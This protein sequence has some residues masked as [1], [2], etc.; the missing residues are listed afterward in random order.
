LPAEIPQALAMLSDDRR[1]SALNERFVFQFALDCLQLG[2][3]LRYFFIEPF[4]FR[5]VINLDNQ[6]KLAP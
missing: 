3:D 2:F 1:R 4:P 6:K 5:S